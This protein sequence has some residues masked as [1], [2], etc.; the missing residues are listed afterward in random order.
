MTTETAPG[1]DGLHVLIK[2]QVARST[3]MTADKNTRNERGEK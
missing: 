3:A 1:Q 2:V